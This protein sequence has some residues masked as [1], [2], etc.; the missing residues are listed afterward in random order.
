AKVLCH[1]VFSDTGGDAAK[2]MLALVYRHQGFRAESG[3]MRNICLMGAE[4]LENGIR[5]LPAVGGRIADLAAIL[6]PKDWFDAFAVRLNPEKAQGVSLALDFHV[7]GQDISLTIA[8]QTEFARIDARHPS[9]EVRVTIAQDALER[10]AA[11][12]LTLKGAVD[13]GAVIDGDAEAVQSWLDLHDS[14]DLW[15]AIATP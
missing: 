5:P 8:R 3:I 10:I 11:G 15:F 7:D 12:E 13:E 6:T 1:L 14:F 4:E 2:R 9:P